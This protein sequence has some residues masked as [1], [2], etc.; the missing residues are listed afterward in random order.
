MEGDFLCLQRQTYQPRG[1][2]KFVGVIYK[3]Y[4]RETTNFNED[5]RLTVS[6]RDE[7]TEIIHNYTYFTTKRT[8][9]FAQR[10]ERDNIESV[11]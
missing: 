7:I 5:K 8:H 6:L 9:F 4:T 11:Y 10:S 2:D 1:K 3:D